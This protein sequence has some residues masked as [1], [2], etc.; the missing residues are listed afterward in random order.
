M[1]IAGQVGFISE[2]PFVPTV[3][4]ASQESKVSGGVGESETR[5]DKNGMSQWSQGVEPIWRSMMRDLFK[6]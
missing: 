2:P 6:R 5:V 1:T 3:H 4:F